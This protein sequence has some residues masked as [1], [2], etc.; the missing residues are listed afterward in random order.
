MT[1]IEITNKQILE[2]VL[3]CNKELKATIEAVEVRISL[4]VEEIKHKVEK[5]E[6][7]NQELKSKIEYLERAGKKNSIVIFGLERREDEIIGVEEA[8]DILKNLLDINLVAS[9]LNNVYYLG[10]TEKSPLKIEFTSFFKKSMILKSASKL[11]GTQIYIANDLTIEQREE[12]KILRKHLY[13][14]RQNEEKNC[15]IKNN[16]LFVDNQIYT[17]AELKASQVIFE[18][19]RANS[20]PGTPINIRKLTQEEGSE[21]GPLNIQIPRKKTSKYTEVTHNPRKTLKTDTA[22]K[23]IKENTPGRPN[24]RYNSISK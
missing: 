4:Q 12:G 8:I 14:A 18:D 15:F 1:E 17:A 7:E 22:K 13:L 19:T 6:R 23:P 10:K 20:D 3:R 21:K 24:T 2:E 9:D 11:K 16:K 5:V